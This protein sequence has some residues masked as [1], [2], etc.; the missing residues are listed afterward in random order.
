MLLP[1]M[2][3]SKVAARPMLVYCFGP[4]E[5]ETAR[6]ELRKFGLPVKLERKPLQLLITLVE[7]AGEVVTR[8]ELQRVLWGGDLFVDFENF[9]H[10]FIAFF[11]HVADFAYALGRQ[12]RNVHKTIGAG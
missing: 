9:D 2:S 1:L 10:D 6:K 4:Y 12:L 11:Q 3:A 5:L 8:G 7:R